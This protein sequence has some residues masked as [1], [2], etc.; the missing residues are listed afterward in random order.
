MYHGV[1]DAKHFYGF[2]CTH[3]LAYRQLTLVLFR[4]LEN[5]ACSSVEEVQPDA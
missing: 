3:A 5:R 1:I 2:S 4:E